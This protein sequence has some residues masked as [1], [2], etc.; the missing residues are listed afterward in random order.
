MNISTNVECQ[1]HCR[2][3]QLHFF[4]PHFLATTQ[5]SAV[6][7]SFDTFFGQKNGGQKNTEKE[8]IPDSDHCPI[9]PQM[10]PA[11]TARCAGWRLPR[12]VRKRKL[13]SLRVISRRLQACRTDREGPSSQALVE[14]KKNGR[15]FRRTAGRDSTHSNTTCSNR[16][17][18]L[19][20]R[21]PRHHSASRSERRTRRSH[22]TSR[23]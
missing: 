9:L 1:I 12:R 10:H 3:S 6:C 18:R 21:C 17:T 8:L 14:T 19:R 4:A 7:N 16:A 22:R 23:R 5:T 15:L 20:G 2:R 13:F 11:K